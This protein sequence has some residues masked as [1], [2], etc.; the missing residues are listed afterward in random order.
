LAGG[1]GALAS[2]LGPGCLEVQHELL[3]C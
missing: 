1:S 2:V 3:S